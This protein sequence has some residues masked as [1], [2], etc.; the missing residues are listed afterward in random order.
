MAYKPFDQRLH[1]LCDPP[2]RAAVTEWVKVVWGLTCIENPDK[3]AVDLIVY[4]KDQICGYI[5]VEV[6]DWGQK[7]CPYTSIHIARRK[8]KLFSNVRGTLIF[9]VTRDFENAYWCRAEDVKHSPLVE[10]PNRSVASGEYFY[11][12]PIEHFRYVYLDQPF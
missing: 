12:V 5:E 8:T 1:D 3:Y 7:L 4:R 11:D 9:V 10:V 2:A 6:R